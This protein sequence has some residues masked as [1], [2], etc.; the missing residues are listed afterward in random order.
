M[1]ETFINITS[2]TLAPSKTAY[3][4][5]YSNLNVHNSS[6]HLVSSTFFFVQQLIHL[7]RLI[8]NVHMCRSFFLLLHRAF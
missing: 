5:L 8:T 3:K 6:S 2:V 1:S 4:P 7:L